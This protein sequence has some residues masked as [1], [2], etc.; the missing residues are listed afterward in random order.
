MS[1]INFRLRNRARRVVAAAG[2]AT[3]STLLA[4]PSLA[5][6]DRLYW[7]GD[8]SNGSFD[9][10]QHVHDGNENPNNGQTAA[11][12]VEAP[13]RPGELALRLVAANGTSRERPDRA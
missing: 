13:G 2:F 7:V 11:Q 5:S 1:H 8:I 9:E 10:W 6:A 3:L 4:L 12:I